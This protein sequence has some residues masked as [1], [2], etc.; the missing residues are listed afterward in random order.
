MTNT[1]AST[2]DTATDISAP[3]P[4]KTASKN[5]NL[6]GAKRA[7]FDEFYTQLT[8]VEKE[9]L[10]YK[11]H[12]AGKTVYLNCDDPSFSAFWTFFSLKF[13][14]YGLK[15]LISTHYSA[16]GPPSYAQEMTSGDQEH[17]CVGQCEYPGAPGCAYTVW[18]LQG[19][20]DFRSD[21]SIELLQQSDIVVTNPPFSLFRE[22]VAQLMEYDKDFI[23]LGNQNAITYR[24]IFPLIRDDKM[25]L[26]GYPGT[27]AFRVPSEH[28]DPN[29][30]GYYKDNDGHEYHKM[31]S[32]VWFTNVEHPRRTEQLDLYKRYD[33]NEADYPKYDNY[34]AIEVSRVV[35]IPLDYDGV[36]GVPITFLG[37]HSPE[38]FEIIGCSYNYGRP[39]MWPEDTVMSPSV[40]GK[41]I[42]KRL[43]IRHGVN[44]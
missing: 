16:D 43:F 21:E 35:D 11:D 13:D 19:D 22:Y 14:D 8:D 25:W 3:T 5:S 20:G 44:K 40:G 18:T 15:R 6:H 26:G 4:P 41:N 17:Y 24:E 33:G 32:V 34:D 1:T 10:H 31:R 38:Q 9:M 23:I 36:M 37:K 12:F 30:W 39:E 28:A 29:K 2:A 42:Y 7:K 27:V